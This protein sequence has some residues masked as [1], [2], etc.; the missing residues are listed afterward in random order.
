MKK[1][2]ICL[3]L[4]ITSSA[5]LATADT[6]PKGVWKFDYMRNNYEIAEVGANPT[7]DK[8]TWNRVK[9]KDGVMND[10][11]LLRYLKL[12]LATQTN[13]SIQ[14]N[15]ETKLLH[16]WK[17]EVHHVDIAYGLTDRLTLFANLSHEYAELDY[18]SAYEQQS[19]IIDG[20]LGSGYTRVP[21]KATSNHMN[22]IFLGLKYKLN[23]SIAVAYKTTTG[24]LKTGVDANEKKFSD[25][26]QE[27]E[28]SRGY[29]QHHLYMFYNTQFM[30]QPLHLMLGYAHLGDGPQNFLDNQNI[31]INPGNLIIGKLDVPV[32]ISPQWLLSGSMTTI[33]HGKDKYKGG[34]T[35]FGSANPSSTAGGYTEFTDVP[36]SDSVA[37]IGTLLVSYQPKIFFKLNASWSYM[38]RNNISG[39][40]YDSPGRLQPGSMIKLGGTLFFKSM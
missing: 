9:I 34:N 36:N 40:L 17:K 6:L 27:L 21:D 1:I 18:T 5:I 33:M 23:N 12:A 28:T 24:S 13:N 3:I 35:K 8:T 38:V 4:G 29:D 39:Q 37:M 19:K 22:D 25:G 31:Q 16:Y 20:I 32:K 26:V 30:K 15:L 14:L 10:I 11:Y 2:I 7:G